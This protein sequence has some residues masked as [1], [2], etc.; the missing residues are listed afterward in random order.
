MLKQPQ[1]LGNG[2]VL[3]RSRAEDA[4]RIAE[5]NARIHGDDPEDGA[6]VAGWTRDMASGNHPTMHSDA[7]TIVEEQQ[8]GKIISCMNL[9]PQT[10]T[11]RG[12]PFKVGRPEAVGTDPDFR[13]RGLVRLQFDA[14]HEWSR[15]NGD[16]LQAITGIPYYYRLFGYEM[17]VELD[18]SFI[19]YEANVPKLPEGEQETVAFQEAG[20]K[21]IPFLMQLDARA[22]KP[23]LLSCVRDEK[24]WRY[25]ISGRSMNN[26]SRFKIMIINDRVGK[27]IGAIRHPFYIDHGLSALHGY[28]LAEQASYMNVTP[29]VIRYLWKTG[30]QYSLES[31]K[32]L[33]GFNFALGGDHPAVKVATDR[34]PRKKRPYAWYIRVPDLMNFLKLITPALDDNLAHS[35]CS[36]Y[37]GA[38][39][40]GLF[41]KEIRFSFE[42]GKIT[43]IVEVP[44]PDDEQ[45]DVTFPGLTFL[46]ILFGWRT[47]QELRFALPDCLLKEEKTALVE[48]LFPKVP[49]RI[50]ALE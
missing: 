32:T 18:A 36:G 24:I 10:W 40:V 11:Y 12:I 19:G 17:T 39:R 4:D 16:M 41:T 2:L 13:N 26:C 31:G 20:E 35:S 22:Q 45:M 46:Q 7:F 3:R 33:T 29:A 23:M 28:E 6:R 8:S 43:E 15:Q 48:G 47:L 34:F 42:Q 49:S 14:V 37:S 27:P 30:Q 21:D 44:H 25:E 5:F 38:L 50:W 9:I 1:D